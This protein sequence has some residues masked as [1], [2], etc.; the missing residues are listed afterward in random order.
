MINNKKSSSEVVTA[1]VPQGSIDCSLL[2]NL[3]INNLV[4]FLDTTVLSNYA[5]DNNLYAI[6]DE[7]EK[8]KK[9]LSKDF[10]TII[11][12]FSENYMILNTEKYHYMCVGKDEDENETL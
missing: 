6:G 8:T 2:F 10:Q 11:I 12:W 1:G 3:F 4:L 9:T 7:K 5:D